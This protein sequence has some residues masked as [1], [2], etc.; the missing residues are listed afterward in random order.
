MYNLKFFISGSTSLYIR[1]KT[2]DSFAGRVFSFDI[3][4]KYVLP[5]EVKYKSKIRNS[6]LNNM[7]LF[8][9]KFHLPKAVILLNTSENQTT[10]FKG[11]TVEMKPV[12]S[13]MIT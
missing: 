4:D 5:V 3:A 12:F 10:E 6:D 7:F 1:K 11:L 13:A 8:C 2:Q 9:K